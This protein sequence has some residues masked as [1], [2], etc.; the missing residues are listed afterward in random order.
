MLKN[1]VQIKTFKY[2]AVSSLKAKINLISEGGKTT[3]DLL[4]VHL[5][6]DRLRNN[7]SPVLK[8]KHMNQNK[9]VFY[10]KFINKNCMK[11]IGLK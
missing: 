9:Q 11:K 2:S 5:I 7:C 8:I 1:R 3:V 4:G 10:K 6:T